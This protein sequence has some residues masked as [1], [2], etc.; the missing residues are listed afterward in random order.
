MIINGEKIQFVFDIRL[1]GKTN[2]ILLET[3][4]WI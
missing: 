2:E 1:D 3:D 4:E